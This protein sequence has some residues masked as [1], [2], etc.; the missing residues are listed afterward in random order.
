VVLALGPVSAWAGSA[1]RAGGIFGRF[2]CRQGSRVGAATT[3][4]H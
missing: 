4:L 2:S 1:Q 3:A